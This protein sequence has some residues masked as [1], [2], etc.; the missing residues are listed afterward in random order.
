LSSAAANYAPN[1]VENQ[2]EPREEQS[3]LENSFH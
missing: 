3:P 1:R 2:Q